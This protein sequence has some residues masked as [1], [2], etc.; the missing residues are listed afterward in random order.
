MQLTDLGKVDVRNVASEIGVS[1]DLLSKIFIVMCI[2]I[3]FFF[4]FFWVNTLS[5]L[6]DAGLIIFFLILET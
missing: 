4:F 2:F 3:N 1:P 6:I 5:M